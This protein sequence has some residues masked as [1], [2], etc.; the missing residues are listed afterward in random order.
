[1]MRFALT[2]GMSFRVVHILNKLLQNNHEIEYIFIQKNLYRYTREKKKLSQNF[3]KNIIF[4]CERFILLKMLK[5]PQTIS[6]FIIGRYNDLK[7]KR[8]KKSFYKNLT[9]QKIDGDYFHVKR[10]LKKII[11]KHK[12][13]T[14]I[15]ILENI[16]SGEISKYEFDYL[17]VIGGSILSE[18][19]LM[20]ARKNC[21][22]VH[23][24][25]L[26]KL[27]GFGGGEIWAAINND[28][29]SL[30]YSIIKGNKKI[31]SGEIL[32]QEKLKLKKKESF[33]KLILRNF[34]LGTN[35]IIK[36]FEKLKSHNFKFKKQSD[37]KATYIKRHPSKQEYNKGLE[38][39]EKALKKL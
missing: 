34:D 8:F 17:F 7:K 23:N 4:F 33:D 12:T 35:L 27:R 30:G 13:K 20:A 39:Y 21:L 29:D 18:K 16:N 3:L 31:D 37:S 25:Y 26:P 36:S 1:M 9:L 32:L 11:E 38:N 19:T 24:T 10:C 2:G 28:F 22:I 5:L 15:V 6:D 14:K